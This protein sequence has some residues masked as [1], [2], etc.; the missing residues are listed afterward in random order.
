MEAQNNLQRFLD[1][2]DQTYD[3]ALAEIR[4][5]HKES[6][7]MWYIFP[8]LLGLGFSD[9]AKFYGI[10]GLQ[11]ANAY[12]SHPVLGPR[13]LEVTNSVMQIPGKSAT[14]IFGVP[15]DV[16][17]RSCMTLFALTDNA[18]PIFNTAVEKY[19]NGLQDEY[20]LDLLQKNY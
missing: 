9:I 2:Q 18:D 16:K 15:D 3:T 4:N 11:E 19:F 5:G 14:Q 13:L 6:H 12:F 7:W 20:T 17:F 8:Q 10:R 1:A